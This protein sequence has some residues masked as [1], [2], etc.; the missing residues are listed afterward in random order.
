MEFLDKWERK[1]GWM[2]FP[3]LLRYYALFH[4]LVFLLQYINPGIA[5]LLEFDLGKI[6]SGEVWRAVTFLFSTSGLGGLG[7]LTLLFIYFM[8]VIGF[9]V[10]DGLEEAWGI[11]RTSMFLYT[12]FFGL[13]LANVVYSLIFQQLLGI[14]ISFPGTGMFVYESA[15]LAFAT[16]FPQVELL[17]FFILPVQVRWLAM[18]AALGLLF[19]VFQSPL[20]IGFIILGFGNYLLWAGIPA[21][22]GKARI[23]RSTVRR[24]GFQ[25]KIMDN[26][27]SFHRCVKCDRTEVSDP[28][29]EF[30][31]AENGKEYCEEHLEE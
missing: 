5:G 22:R 4:V 7:G 10:S 23:A 1:L 17:I 20:I 26:E 19:S 12:G 18:F 14:S 13:L 15:F 31:M 30:R 16:L 2:S 3:G 8:V 27:E 11:F 29:L 9:M 28:D 25:K 6:L 24:K 21:L